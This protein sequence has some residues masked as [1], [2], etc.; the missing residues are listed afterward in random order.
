MNQQLLKA[1]LSSVALGV[2]VLRKSYPGLLDST[3]LIVIAFAVLPWLA[4]LIHRAELPGGLNIDFRH[5]QDAGA[6]IVGQETELTKTAAPQLFFLGI[7]EADP[8]LALVGLR[9]ELERLL[10]NIAR[11]KSMSDRLPLIQILHQLQAEEVLSDSAVSGIRELVR[12]G[13]QA[14]HGAQVSPE[15][16]SWAMDVGPHVLDV[17]DKA[18][19]AT[20]D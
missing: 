2:I 16:V 7:A 10:R 20:E 15:T 13:N 6:K 11:R 19:L 18:L 9:I 14:A 1:A 8:N 17:L 12:F 5:V 4:P 3:D